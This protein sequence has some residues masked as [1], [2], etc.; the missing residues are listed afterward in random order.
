MMKFKIVEYG[1]LNELQKNKAVEL[2][3]EGFGVK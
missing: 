2:F 1:C 3:I